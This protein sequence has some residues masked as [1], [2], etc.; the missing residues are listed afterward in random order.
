MAKIGHCGLVLPGYS[1][2]LLNCYILQGDTALP[3]FLQGS[4][5]FVILQ[6]RHSIF[7]N[8]QG[9]LW[10]SVGAGGLYKSH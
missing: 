8:H 1:R 6:R 3:L 7:I 2:E 9:L 10:A 4:I 5:I